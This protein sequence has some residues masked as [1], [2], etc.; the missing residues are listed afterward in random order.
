MGRLFLA[1]KLKFFSVA[2]GF[3]S[4]LLAANRAGMWGR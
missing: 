3:S 4:I 2:S 1:A